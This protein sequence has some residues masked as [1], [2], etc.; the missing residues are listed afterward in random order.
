ML[1]KVFHCD[2]GH[3][4]AIV[5]APKTDEQMPEGWTR[6]NIEMTEGGYVFVFCPQCSRF[7]DEV[8]IAFGMPR[9]PQPRGQ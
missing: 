9:P 8:L 7:F 3:E 6:V 2:R 1:T 4:Q 5:V